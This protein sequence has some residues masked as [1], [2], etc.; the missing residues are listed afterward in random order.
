MCWP[1]FSVLSVSDIAHFTPHC[2]YFRYTV[3]II[4][5]R[6]YFLTLLLDVCASLYGEFSAMFFNRWSHSLHSLFFLYIAPIYFFN[7]LYIEFMEHILNTCVHAVTPYS[8][9]DQY[10]YTGCAKRT[11]HFYQKKVT[12]KL[13]IANQKNKNHRP[14]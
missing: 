11:A 7:T 6:A 2:L 1:Y 10:Q 9:C 3:P 8:C 4:S 5:T 13:L 12:E 14:F